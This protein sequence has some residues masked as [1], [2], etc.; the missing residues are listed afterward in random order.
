MSNLLN[1][2]F[3]DIEVNSE[4][5]HCA[6]PRSF[7]NI[8]SGSFILDGRCF[9]SDKAHIQYKGSKLK[10]GLLLTYDPNQAQAY[11]FLVCRY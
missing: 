5:S 10:V 6:T 3:Q 8:I 11:N 2:S 4:T 7:H 1:Y 9:K